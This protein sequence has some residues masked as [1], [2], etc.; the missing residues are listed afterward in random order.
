V[1]LTFINCYEVKWATMV[2]D[3]FT[4]AK[5]FALFIIIGTGLYQLYLGKSLSLDTLQR[6]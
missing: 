2:Q 5:L 6:S 4:Y 3:Y 1:L